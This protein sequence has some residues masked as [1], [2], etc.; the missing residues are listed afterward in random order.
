MKV[1]KSSKD[2]TLNPG[3]N[4]L[5]TIGNTVSLYFGFDEETFYTN[6]SFLR[7][8][9]TEIKADLGRLRELIEISMDSYASSIPPGLQNIGYDNDADVK[10]ALDVLDRVA[11]GEIVNPNN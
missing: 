7:Y 8:G 10:T 5:A 2:N 11:L 1:G 6:G 4:P 3:N 9:V